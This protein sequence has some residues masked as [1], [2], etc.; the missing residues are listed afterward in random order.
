[1]IINNSS[2]FMSMSNLIFIRYK[3]MDMKKHMLVCLS[4]SMVVSKKRGE[5]IIKIKHNYQERVRLLLLLLL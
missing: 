4:I 2:L 1:M 5:I 3:Y